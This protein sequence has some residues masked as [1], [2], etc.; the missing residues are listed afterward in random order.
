MVNIL[1]M[2]IAQQ[3][4]NDIKYKIESAGYRMSDLCRVAEINQAQVSRWQNGIT[5]PLY[6]TVVRLEQ[7]ADA[8]ISARLQVLNKAMEDAVK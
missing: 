1:R 6:S 3:A 5:E 8:L 2:K 7:A 4:I